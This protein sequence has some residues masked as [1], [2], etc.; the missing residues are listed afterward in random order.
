MCNRVTYVVGKDGRIEYVE[1]S[2]T[3]IDP[4]GADEACSRIAHREAAQQKK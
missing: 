1:A 3:A 4:S 2:N